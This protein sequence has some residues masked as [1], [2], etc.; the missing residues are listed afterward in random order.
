MKIY[1]T[2]TRQ[3]EEFVPREEGKVK[4]YTCGPTVYNFAHIGNL[5]TYMME[6]VLEKYLRYIGYDVTRVM[7]ITDIGH[8]SSDA[9]SGEDKMLL[10]AKREH[11]TVLELAK[12][13]TDAFFKDCEALHIKRPDVVQPATGCIDEFIKVISSLIEKGYAY[14]AGGNVYFVTSKL[15]VYH[16]FFNFK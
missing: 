5:R 9:D 2:L 15:K 4:M 6:D 8:L 13:Y 16:V 1:N 11:K 12:F 14:L 7:N 3:T 10:G